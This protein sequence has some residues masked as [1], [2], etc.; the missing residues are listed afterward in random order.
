MEPRVGYCNYGSMSTGML[1]GLS[2]PFLKLCIY[3]LTIY[4]LPP[5]FPLD[6]ELSP[7]FHSILFFMKS[8][9]H[10]I[11][12]PVFNVLVLGSRFALVL[13]DRAHLPKF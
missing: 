3:L 6:L 9:I 8:Y 2:I 4:L 11:S 7:H 13:S 12:T 5:S 1:N 10:R